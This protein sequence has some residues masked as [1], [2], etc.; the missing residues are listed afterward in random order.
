MNFLN[1]DRRGTG[2]LL[3]MFV[4]IVMAL[5]MVLTITYVRAS[6][7]RS[8]A[9]SVEHTIALQCLASCYTHPNKYNDEN[10]WT[11]NREFESITETGQP[12]DPL[13]QFNDA[14]VTYRLMNT[15]DLGDEQI[16][17]A[18]KKADA[19]SVR[20]GKK[21]P[22]FEIQIS[23]WSCYDTWWDHLSKISPNPVKVVIEADYLPSTI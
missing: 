2:G 16:S 14:M 7:A 13:Q 10:F 11:G 3:F 12:I 22:S 9:E 1:A 15:R 4:S 17:M 23:N 21:V 5:T 8:V 19:S 6:T 20:K 18:Y